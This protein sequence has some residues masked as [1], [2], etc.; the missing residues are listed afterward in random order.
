[1]HRQAPCNAVSKPPP[2]LSGVDQCVLICLVLTPGRSRFCLTRHASMPCQH[3]QS[4]NAWH[5]SCRAGQEHP[6]GVSAAQPACFGA[7]SARNPSSL[8]SVLMSAC[9]AVLGERQPG[10][11]RAPADAGRGRG[12]AAVPAATARR[13]SAYPAEIKCHRTRRSCR[14]YSRHHLC[15][16]SAP[17]QNSQSGSRLCCSSVKQCITSGSQKLSMLHAEV[18]DTS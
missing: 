2:K 4:Q 3:V 9:P 17:P 16:G 10:G 15:M 7:T 8:I 14:G 12:V 18:L 6:Y 1:M 5:V 11:V 13:T